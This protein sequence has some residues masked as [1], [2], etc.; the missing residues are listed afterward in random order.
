MFKIHIFLFA[1][2]NLVQ[3][4]HGFMETQNYVDII[5]HT[6]RAIF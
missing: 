3:S 5:P 2:S 6:I 4:V 1:Y